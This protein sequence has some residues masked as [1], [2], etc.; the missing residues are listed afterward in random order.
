MSKSQISF[1]NAANAKA[2][3][4]MFLAETVVKSRPNAKTA[5]RE[6]CARFEHGTCRVTADNAELRREMAD[7]LMV[8][9]LSGVTL[10][11]DCVIRRVQRAMRRCSGRQDLQRLHFTGFNG[12]AAQ[13]L[14]L[15]AEAE[16]YYST[17]VPPE[18]VIKTPHL[19]AVMVAGDATQMQWAIQ[20]ATGQVSMTTLVKVA[21]HS[22]YSRAQ[23]WA[24]ER[25]HNLDLCAA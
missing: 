1:L 18:R 17:A 16:Q 3:S 7:A 22:L 6:L 4:D 8:V 14:V 24:A 12:C 9:A 5:M 15:M 11:D 19:C 10:D 2:M 23:E 25:L 13:M 20:R 21:E